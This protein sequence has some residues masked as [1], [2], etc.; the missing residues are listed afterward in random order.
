MRTFKTITFIASSEYCIETKRI[1][2]TQKIIIQLYM[3][4]QKAENTKGLQNTTLQ[5]LKNSKYQK[6]TAV[7]QQPAVVSETTWD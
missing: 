1:Q 5:K 2:Y 6:H 3:D 7:K 4:A